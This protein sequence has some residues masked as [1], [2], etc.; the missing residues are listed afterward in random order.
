MTD[1]AIITELSL[2]LVRI[3]DNP[4]EII[5]AVSTQDVLVAIVRRMG[6]NALAL[7]PKDL[8]QARAMVRAALTL[9]NPADR[10]YINDGLNAWETAR[11]ADPCDPSHTPTRSTSIWQT[12]R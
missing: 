12:T 5:H 3:G 1:H 2:R 6:N 7:K 4:Q 10:Q 8:L 11:A 9:H